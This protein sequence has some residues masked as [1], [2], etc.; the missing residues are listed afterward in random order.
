LK[1]HKLEWEGD[2]GGVGDRKEERN[3]TNMVLRGN[4]KKEK[5]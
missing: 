1:G 2:M 3:D 4:L 5:K